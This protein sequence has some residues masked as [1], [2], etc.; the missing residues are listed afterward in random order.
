MKVAWSSDVHLNFIDQKR[1][2]KWI[3]EFAGAD[4]LLLSGD[5]A[6]SKDIVDWLRFLAAQFPKDIY[7]VLGNHD[8]YHSSIAVVRKAVG[9]LVQSIGNLH[10]L[11]QDGPH[12]LTSKVILLGH[13]GWG[14]AKNGDFLQTPIRINDHRLIEELTSLPRP[15]LQKRLQ[16]LGEQAAD[17]I[18]RGLQKAKEKADEIWVLTHVPPFPETCWH[19]GYAGHKD[20]IP[21]FSC[22]SVGDML[23]RF[24]AENPTKQIKVFCGHGHSPGEVWVRPNLFVR[25]ARAEYKYPILEALMVLPS[26]A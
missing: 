4:V 8:Y 5:I 22:Q 20:W 18:E 11:S 9:E 23:L 10:Y 12:Q 16:A 13:D 21:D 25:T 7:F 1:A 14:D 24:C 17:H 2:K 3:D 26:W 19:N 15:V 6:E